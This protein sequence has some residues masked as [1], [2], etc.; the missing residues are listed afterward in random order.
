MIRIALWDVRAI[1][2]TLNKK[3]VSVLCGFL[4][5]EGYSQ[6]TPSGYLEE[7]YRYWEYRL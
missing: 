3:V 2:C 6:L 1:N 4:R 7:Y 5:A